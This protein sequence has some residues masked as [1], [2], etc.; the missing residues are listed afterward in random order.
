MFGERRSQL[1]AGWDDERIC[2]IRR[3]PR[4]PALTAL[5]HNPF[6]SGKTRERVRPPLLVSCGPQTRLMQSSLLGG[7]Q[8]VSGRLTIPCNPT[9]TER[10]PP[11]L[12]LPNR[13]RDWEKLFLPSRS[14]PCESV[15]K[16]CAFAVCGDEDSLSAAGRR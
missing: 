6:A 5:E 11:L 14:S 12:P 3:P 4:A 1:I 7:R 16:T 8:A 13:S 10:R 15:G 2:S 9:P